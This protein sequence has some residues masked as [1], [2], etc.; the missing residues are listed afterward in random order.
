MS[1][2]IN[3]NRHKRRLGR[4][5]REMRERA[6]MTLVEAAARLD[7]T[8]ASLHRVEVGQTLADVHLIRTMMDIYDERDDSLLELSREAKKKGWWYDYFGPSSEPSYVEDEAAASHVALFAAL[9]IPGLLQTEE[10]IRAHFAATNIAG[11]KTHVDDVVTVRRIRQERLSDAERPLYLRA[12]ID[13]SALRRRV[14]G[15]EVMRGQLRRLVAMADLPTVTLQ[16]L[17]ANLGAHAAMNGA[18]TVLTFPE[19]DETDVQYVDYQGGSARIEQPDRVRETKLVFE[20]LCAMALTP[21]DSIPP[22]EEV[23]AEL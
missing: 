22:I 13:E 8:R 5:L 1:G 3:H 20:H 7:K 16:V 19:P 10:Y 18:F 9:T 12:V 6:G 17:P 15:P 14:G 4:K 21:E 11:A 2:Q 23:I